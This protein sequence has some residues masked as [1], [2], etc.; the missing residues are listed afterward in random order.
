LG[1]DSFAATLVASGKYINCEGGNR[2]FGGNGGTAN[3]MF[4]NCVG[5]GL[6]FGSYGTASGTFENC[7]GLEQ[8]FGG[9]AAGIEVASGTFKNCRGGNLSFGGYGVA[10]GTFENCIAGQDSFCSDGGT[11]SG[12][13][14]FCRLTDGTFPT[15]TAPGLIRAS[16]DGND[17]FYSEINP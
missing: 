8:S 3:G 1:I 15:P 7:I 5:G 13:L 2:A 6:S 14:Y 17:V 4:I 9:G 10:S 11:L 12:K 16:I